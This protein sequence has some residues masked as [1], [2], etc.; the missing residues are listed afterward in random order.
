MCIVVFW[1]VKPYI[2]VCAYQRSVERINSVFRVEGK[3]VVSII[4]SFCKRSDIIYVRL[5]LLSWPVT[6]DQSDCVSSHQASHITRDQF[7]CV[8]SHQALHI[9]RIHGAANE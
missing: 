2:L 3:L 1:V 8:S 9:T 7:D 6:R 5:S 4:I